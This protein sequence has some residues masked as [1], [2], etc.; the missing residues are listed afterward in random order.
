M[1]RAGRVAVVGLCTFSMLAA[2]AVAQEQPPPQPEP[3]PAGTPT[4]P[5][6]D[7]P[8][9]D[10]EA[11]AEGLDEPKIGS[12]DE[13]EEPVG[14]EPVRWGIA[15]RSYFVFVPEA[16]FNLFVDHST[17]MQSVSFAGSVIRRKG[18]FDIQLTLEYGRFAPDDGLWQEKDEDPSMVGMYPDY[19]RFGDLGMISV[20]ASF[21]WHV[22]LTDFMQ[23]RYGAGIGVGV[24][25][26]DAT[27]TDTM[28]DS[29]TTVDDLDDPNRCTEIPTSRETIDIPPVLPVINLLLGL[30]F[31]LVDE[32]SLNIETGFRFP[33]FFVG[34]S[35]G[36]FF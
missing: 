10:A 21:I 8:N 24:K 15:A 7:M 36:Y 29:T 33:A 32:L 14:E 34:G 4:T 1:K 19:N 35:V 28:C 20:D 11:D 26:G 31:K 16:L 23:F 9:I 17:P 12:I 27:E 3:Q 30:R 2:P 22:N 13:P 25:L 5:P 6:P 18:N